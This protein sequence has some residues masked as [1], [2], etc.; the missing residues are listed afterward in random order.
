MLGG[1]VINPR[2]FRLVV[3][4]GLVLIAASALVAF[5]VI[6]NASATCKSQ[7]RTLGVLALIVTEQANGPHRFNA[8]VDTARRAALL[9]VEL[10]KIQEAKCH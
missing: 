2:R 5:V 9:A 8:P 4:L 1:W 6:T 7:N 3:V 10:T